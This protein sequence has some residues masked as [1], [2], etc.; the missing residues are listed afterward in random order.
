MATPT[1]RQ[2]AVSRSMRIGVHKNCSSLLRRGIVQTFGI[3]VV[4]FDRTAKL[5]AGRNGSLIA[6]LNAPNDSCGSGRRFCAADEARTVPMGFAIPQ[7]ITPPCVNDLPHGD[8]QNV[9]STHPAPSEQFT[10][11]TDATTFSYCL[12]DHQKS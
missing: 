10:A 8:A 1:E 5:L 12:P 3:K 2:T 11:S 9:H 4:P 6:P 7:R